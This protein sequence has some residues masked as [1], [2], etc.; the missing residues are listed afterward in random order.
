MSDG[1]A[2]TA[3]SSPW[4]SGDMRV[5]GDDGGY[6]GNASNC[7][8]APLNL[9]KTPR[10]LGRKPRVKGRKRETLHDI[11]RRVPVSV[12]REYF[13]FSLRQA[14]DAMNISVTSLKRLCR[15]H[16]VKRWP[17]RQLSGLNRAVANLEEK[18]QTS[19][20]PSIAEQLHQLYSRRN[21]IIDQAFASDD[22]GSE[23]RQDSPSG[24]GDEEG[25]ALLDAGHQEW[26][27]QDA[28]PTP[29][30]LNGNQGMM[31]PWRQRGPDT[32]LPHQR[33]QHS[34][35]HDRG[36]EAVEG[37]QARGRED[38][39]IRGWGRW[40]RSPE[41]TRD[42]SSSSSSSS[43]NAVS[44]GQGPRPPAAAS[45]LSR[46]GGAAEVS[47]A[48]APARSSVRNG[49]N[50]GHPREKVSSLPQHHSGG[51]FEA[52]INKIAVLNALLLGGG[53]SDGPAAPGSLSRAR[54]TAGGAHPRR[55]LCSEGPKEGEGGAWG[56]S[57]DDITGPLP[58]IAR[59][60]EAGALLSGAGDDMNAMYNRLTDVLMPNPFERNGVS[61]LL[62]EHCNRMSECLRRQR[63]EWHDPMSDRM[64]QRGEITRKLFKSFADVLSARSVSCKPV[65]QKRGKAAGAE[66]M[67]SLSELSDL[68]SSREK[69]AALVAHHVQPPAAHSVHTLAAMSLNEHSNATPT[70][71]RLEPARLSVA[72]FQN[73]PA[74][75]PGVHG[76]PFEK[77]A[78]SV[79]PRQQQQQQQPQLPS[80]VPRPPADAPR[81]DVLRYLSQHNLCY[82]QAFSGKCNRPQCTF[83]HDTWEVPTGFYRSLSCEGQAEGARPRRVMAALSEETYAALVD[84]GLAGEERKGTFEGEASDLA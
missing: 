15:R 26:P 77:S 6:E 39:P 31:T 79:Q 10:K 58:S 49:R 23:P 7:T 3:L 8:R 16:G 53:P 50:P 24:S 70:E 55:R 84:M 73:Q 44:M 27:E 17:H 72:A 29:P 80:A 25:D 41:R 64:V 83:S 18:Q 78:G 21:V 71:R 57:Q 28:V 36:Y 63:F 47:T 40:S 45:P 51:S 12:M 54:T 52:P 2:A 60:V 74:S 82:K 34:S 76:V 9:P 56:T 68:F 20:D 5:D 75:D 43:S 30:R 4:L 19:S 42:C 22:T 38:Y 14:A 62:L 1:G 48:T 65:R 46:A 59:L 35:H 69:L 37:T 81:T 66:S 32:N 13:N 61:G 33:Q 11:A 67:F